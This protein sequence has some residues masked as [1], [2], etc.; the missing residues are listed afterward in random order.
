MENWSFPT[1][2]HTGIL[3]GKIVENLGGSDSNG[4]IGKIWKLKNLQKIN[5]SPRLS[6]GKKKKPPLFSPETPRKLEKQYTMYKLKTPELLKTRWKKWKTLWENP[7]LFHKS[8]GKPGGK[9]G[10][11]P[12]QT[13]GLSALTRKTRGKAFWLFTWIFLNG[14]GKHDTMKNRNGSQKRAGNLFLM[15]ASAYEL[16]VQTGT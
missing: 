5:L 16:A 12:A 9:S 1:V 7:C 4:E 8:G 11:I 15:E 3:R 6:F 2:F 14:A 13:I 10:K